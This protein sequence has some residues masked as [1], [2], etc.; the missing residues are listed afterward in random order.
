[1]IGSSTYEEATEEYTKAE[2]IIE[3]LEKDNTITTV[4]IFDEEGEVIEAV[5]L[6]D[7]ILFVTIR[8]ILS[9]ILIVFFLLF[10][11]HSSIIEEI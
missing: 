5:T 9:E 8:S 11:R 4:D 1:M 6:T 10:V 7:T 2:Q 3:A